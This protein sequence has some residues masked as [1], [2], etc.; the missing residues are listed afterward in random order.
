M[1][2]IGGTIGLGAAICLGRLAQ[3]MLYQLNGSDL[4]VFSGSALVLVLV[5][6]GAGSI[7]AHRASHVHPMQALR[8]E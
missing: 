3:S 4:A 5:A 2:F 7:P 6:L 8:Y 1:T